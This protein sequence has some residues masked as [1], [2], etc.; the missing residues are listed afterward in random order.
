MNHL[1]LLLINPMLAKKIYYFALGKKIK[2]L[3]QIYKL[4]THLS[5]TIFSSN[6]YK[7]SGD[8]ENE[9][10]EEEDWEF[11]LDTLLKVWSLVCGF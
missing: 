3:R 10:D 4:W 9:G 1:G 5:S 7:N 2:N 6:L 8:K 11:I